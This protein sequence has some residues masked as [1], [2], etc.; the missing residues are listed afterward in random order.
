MPTDTALIH[1]IA[2]DIANDWQLSDGAR[3]FLTTFAVE[4]LRRYQARK[5]VAENDAALGA[6]LVAHREVYEVVQ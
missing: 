3:D 5:A 4:L 6:V 1:E 2:A